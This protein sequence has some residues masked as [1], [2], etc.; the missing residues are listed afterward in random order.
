M[1]WIS[2]P[3][4]FEPPDATTLEWLEIVTAARWAGVAPWELARRPAAWLEAMK[5]ARDVEVAMERQAVRNRN[6]ARRTE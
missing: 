1:R 3:D 2:A 4:L 6:A 5:T